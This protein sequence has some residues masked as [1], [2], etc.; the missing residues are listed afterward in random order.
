MLVAVTYSTSDYK[1]TRKYNVKMSYK[2]GKVDRVFEFDEKDLSEDFKQRNQKILSCKRGAGYWLWKPYV[3][4]KTLEKLEY[5]DY[6]FYCDSGAFVFK[7]I[8][9]LIPFMEKQQT[10]ILFF[11]IDMIEKKWTKRDVFIELQCDC[12]EYADSKQRCATY[13]LIKKTKRTEIF[14]AE[15][16]KYA[17]KYELISD[18]DNVLHKQPN[19][20]G[21]CDNRHDQSILSILS[22]KYG[23]P[24]FEDISQYRNGYTGLV[25]IKEEKNLKKTEE[26]PVIVCLHRQKKADRSTRIRQCLVDC[27]PKI[28]RYIYWGYR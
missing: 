10:D 6:L 2:K 26:Y 13:F 5:G 11:E 27:F 14:V 17:Q 16:L 22:K 9:S 20:E 3:V 23:Y 24:A 25:R 21:F 18:E 1:K 4:N 19:Y 12:K 8:H 7:D 15:W 28:R